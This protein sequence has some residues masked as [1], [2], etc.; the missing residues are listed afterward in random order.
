M[1][2]S[3]KTSFLLENTIFR[4]LRA[5][6]SKI[7][8]LIIPLMAGLVTALSFLE[9]TTPTAEADLFV[10]EIL[11]ETKPSLIIFQGNSLASFLNPS[12]EEPRPTRRLRVVVTAY[13]STPWETDTDPY[14]TASGNLVREGVVANN[15]L[16]FGTKIKIPEIFGD[17]VFVVE[18]RMSWGKSDYHIDVWFP[19]YWEALNFGT[20][21]T[22]IEILEG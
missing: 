15:F 2:I 7:Y 12:F 8:V 4:L 11:T 10:A 21:M 16:P 20:K 19:S 14:I 3:R 22:Y 6:R 13:S 9:F 17:K 5:R 18:D 1:D